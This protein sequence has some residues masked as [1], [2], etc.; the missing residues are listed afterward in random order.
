M[1]VPLFLPVVWVLSVCLCVAVH[2]APAYRNQQMK[3]LSDLFSL[4]EA[5]LL[6]G[7]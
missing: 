5:C 3:P 7:R 1:G 4:S 6:A 2:V